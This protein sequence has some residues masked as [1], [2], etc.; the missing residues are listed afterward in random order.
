MALVA[1]PE[2]GRPELAHFLCLT[3]SCLL[4]CFNAVERPWPEAKQILV[5]H[6][7]FPTFRTK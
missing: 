4:A 5:P 1:L 7:D 3:I 2:Q 6:S